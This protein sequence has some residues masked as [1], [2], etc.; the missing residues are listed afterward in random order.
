[1]VDETKLN[2]FIGKILGDLGGVFSA[3]LVRMGDK[4]GL[5]KALKEK[6]PMTP[7][8]WRQRRTWPSATRAN[9]CR[10]RQR[11][12]ISSTSL[13]LASSRYRRNR[14]WCSPSLTVPSICNPRSTWRRSCW[15]TSRWSNLHS[16]PARASAG[17]ISRNVFSARPDASFAQAIKTISSASWLP[18]L[19]RRRRE[20]RKRRESRRRWLRSRLFDHHHG[21]SLSEIDVRRLRLSSRRRWRRRGFM[22]SSMERPR[23]RSSKSPWRAIFQARTW[24]W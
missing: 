8:S 18:T 1:M 15:K 7:T 17:A 24:T 19:G 20:T 6:G 22:P 11:Q 16:A 10:I 2:Q 13:P 9:G 12:D 14:R 23:T 4:L 21:E 5:Y 3:P